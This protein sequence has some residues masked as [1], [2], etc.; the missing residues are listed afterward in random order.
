MNFFYLTVQ[1]VQTALFCDNFLREV[2]LINEGNSQKL[3]ATGYEGM[4]SEPYYFY[5]LN[6]DPGALIK[7]KCY[8]Y[9]GWSFG[10][11][12]F[13]I[14]NKCRC[15]MFDSDIKQY[16]NILGPHSGKITFKNNIQ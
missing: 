14:N 16:T 3:I 10:A 1:I 12:C 4:W 5:D 7:F 6:V 2:Y 11:G 15:Y 8:T 9:N 13:L